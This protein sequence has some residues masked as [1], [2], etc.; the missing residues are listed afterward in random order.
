MKGTCP[1]C[2]ADS[3]LTE[4]APGVFT[5]VVRHDDTCPRYNAAIRNDRR[6]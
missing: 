6:R 2:N 1:D 3:A 5:L 4:M